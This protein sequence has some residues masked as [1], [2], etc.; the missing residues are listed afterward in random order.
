MTHRASKA[1]STLHLR[2]SLVRL[3]S[4]T[5]HP[6]H[7]MAPNQWHHLNSRRPSTALPTSSKAPEPSS[8]N[9]ARAKSCSSTTKPATNISSPK[10]AEISAK[11]EIK[12]G[13]WAPHD[14]GDARWFA[15]AASARRS[16]YPW[17][18]GQG[19][20]MEC[21]ET[22]APVSSPGNFDDA[23]GSVFEVRSI[24]ESAGAGGG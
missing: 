1:A 14:Q 7:S 2:D 23:T 9:S 10:A 24:G 19:S 11:P 13:L 4:R 6:L 20:G 3:P 18:D 15:C 12:S 17:H 22:G 16:G 21:A 5:K 8:S